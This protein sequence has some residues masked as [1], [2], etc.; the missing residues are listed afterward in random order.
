MHFCVPKYLILCFSTSQRSENR[1]VYWDLV[2]ICLGPMFSG[3][4][5]RMLL[6]LDF[7]CL[8]SIKFAKLAQTFS[9]LL[10]KAKTIWFVAIWDVFALDQCFLDFCEGF[11]VCLIS[12]VLMKFCSLKCSLLWLF[13][14]MSESQMLKW[15][16]S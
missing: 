4:W 10:S 3:L 11:G 5:W 16:G 7:T 15:T 8:V 2:C 12:L 1:L 6:I 9:A 13:F 14:Y